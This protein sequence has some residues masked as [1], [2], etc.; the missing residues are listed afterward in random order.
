MDVETA[1]LVG[2]WTQVAAAI[3]TLLA[4]AGAWWAAVVTKRNSAAALFGQFMEQYAS[5]DMLKSLDVL[6]GM[7]AETIRA[8]S[9]QLKDGSARITNEDGVL[10]DPAKIQDEARRHVKYFF[11]RIAWAREDKTL[12]ASQTGHVRDLE[13]TKVLR[14]IVW[15]MEKAHPHLRGEPNLADKIRPLGIT[16]E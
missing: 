6:N 14:E 3:F 4:A 10:L 7:D 11:L 1:R 8:W 15:P 2:T 5:T 9:R 12:T 16:L 13:A